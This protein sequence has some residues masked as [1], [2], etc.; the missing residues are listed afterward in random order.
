[1][2]AA[3]QKKIRQRLLSIWHRQSRQIRLMLVTVVKVL[4]QLF[5]EALNVLHIG[6]TQACLRKNGYAGNMY[7]FICLPSVSTRFRH[8]NRDINQYIS[9]TTSEYAHGDVGAINSLTLNQK[10]RLFVQSIDLY[11][12]IHSLSCSLPIY[13]CVIPREDS[14]S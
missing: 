6:I 12:L 10:E 2:K 11:I 14:E 3:E 1:M 7:T 9:Y 8:V 4:A 5:T 13:I